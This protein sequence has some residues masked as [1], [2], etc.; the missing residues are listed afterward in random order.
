M[1]VSAET[2]ALDSVVVVS[3]GG[4]SSFVGRRNLE[5]IC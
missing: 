2:F 3:M 1:R 4:N 5:L